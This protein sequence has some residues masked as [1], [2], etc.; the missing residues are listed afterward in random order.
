MIIWTTIFCFTVFSCFCR[1]GQGC[2]YTGSCSRHCALVSTM[3]E[4]NGM[5][6]N[7]TEQNV[8]NWRKSPTAQLTDQNLKYV[9]T[10]IVQMPL[11]PWQ[12]WDIN[13]LS[14]PLT[15]FDH[16]LSREMLPNIQYKFPW[17]SFEPFSSVLSLDPRER[18]SAPPS[19]FPYL[20]KF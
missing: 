20:R 16:P 14:K 1:V 13:H 8:F 2:G 12:V 15:A 7:R 3:I 4:R 5:E 18:I 10:S 9:I 11:K 17:S 6:W 19:P